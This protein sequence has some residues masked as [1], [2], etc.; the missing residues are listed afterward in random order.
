MVM[1]GS[2][3]HAS[4]KR[5]AFVGKA[6]PP[7]SPITK[8]PAE[9]STLRVRERKPTEAALMATAE[10]ATSAA[11]APK[12]CRGANRVGLDALDKSEVNAIA[13]G[14]QIKPE[15]MRKIFGID[16][17]LVHPKFNSSEE[18]KSMQKWNPNGFGGLGFKASKKVKAQQFASSLARS[19][20]VPF[21]GLKNLGA[22]CYMNSMLQCLFHTRRFRNGVFQ[23]AEPSVMT[24]EVRSREPQNL[25]PPPHIPLP[26][27]HSFRPNLAGAEGRRLISNL[28]ILCGNISGKIRV[29]GMRG[30]SAG[31]EACLWLALSQ[32]I[33]FS[34]D[35]ARLLTAY[36]TKHLLQ[37]KQRMQPICQL[38]NLFANLKCSK[39]RMYD[40]AP[41]AQSLRIS[42]SV[43]QD[44]QE[45][46]KL[47]LTYMEDNLTLL[48]IE[49][50]QHLKTL[51]QVLAHPP[52]LPTVMMLGRKTLLPSCFRCHALGGNL[53]CHDA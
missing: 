15:T 38:Q 35:P 26:T 23:L 36:H 30:I 52:P 43:Q 22:T 8:A 37:M 33:H 51:I 28:H 13:V 17:P 2:G 34:H 24:E 5:S 18:C 40:P 16:N 4:K 49:T 7:Q 6:A 39:E 11:G 3:S 32:M 1:G 20:E 10:A 46:L 27:P 31:R 21:G 9:K 50:H 29:V 12:N 42:T 53:S 48:P 47:L 14:T 44:A 19:D 25:T 41:F 45:F